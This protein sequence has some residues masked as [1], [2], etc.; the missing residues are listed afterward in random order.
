MS[1]I[2]RSRPSPFRHH[3][4]SLRRFSG[5]WK[6]QTMAAVQTCALGAPNLNSTKVES[7]DMLVLATSHDWAT[8][9]VLWR[10]GAFGSL[11]TERCRLN[12]SADD[13]ALCSADA[14]FRWCDEGF[15]HSC[16][17]LSSWKKPHSQGE[18]VSLGPNLQQ[19]SDSKPR[20]QQ[21]KVGSAFANLLD[22]IAPM[23]QSHL[24]ATIGVWYYSGFCAQVGDVGVSFKSLG[25]EELTARSAED[26]VHIP[27]LQWDLGFFQRPQVVGQHMGQ[28]FLFWYWTLVSHDVFHGYY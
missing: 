12:C 2:C 9:T 13:L 24:H 8:P 27:N 23:L 26:R 11:Y 6:P 16:F 1:H 18:I 14:Q 17:W 4:W 22:L 3:G 5:P 19:D 28:K 20:H 25:A 7:K 10:G 21:S 15:D